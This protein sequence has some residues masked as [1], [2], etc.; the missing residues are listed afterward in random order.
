MDLVLS[1]IVVTSIWTCCSTHRYSA[2]AE[3]KFQSNVFNKEEN[4][5]M[6]TAQKKKSLEFLVHCC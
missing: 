1:G 2:H 4:I 6:Y 3:Q 5:Y